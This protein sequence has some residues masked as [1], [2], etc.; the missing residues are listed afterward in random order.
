MSSLSYAAP[1]SVDDAVK[2]LAGA[3]GLAK[4]LSGGTDLLVQLR[5]GRLKPDLIVDTKK[6]PGI[7]GIRSENGGFVIG[8]ATPGAVVE[9]HAELNAAWPG[10]VE[11][12]DLIGST[13]IQGRCSLAGNLCNASPAADGV[14]PLLALDANVE[15]ASRRG[16]RQL[17]L[18][19]FIA[20]PRRT[21]LAADEILTA[22]ICPAPPAARRSTFLKLGARRYLVISI[23]MVAVGLDIEDDVVR[24]AQLAVGACSAVAMRLPAAERRLAGAPARVGL[25]DRL[26]P[27]DFV[28]LAPID[29]VRADVGYRRAAALTLTQRAV[30]LCLQGESGGA[31]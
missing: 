27:E 7:I 10:V 19:R 31:V 8:A 25:G 29:D 26:Q 21:E 20:G 13:Q 17:P 6:I 3:S 14:P 15:L 23:A 30:E 5:S 16:R 2:L 18:A 11:A 1:T 9:A 4:V 12:L 22:V 24:A 28:D